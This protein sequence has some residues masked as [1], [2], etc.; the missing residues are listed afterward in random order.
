IAGVLI[1][2]NWY[3]FIY[4]VNHVN[5]KSAAFAYLVCRLLLE[6]KSYF[7]LKEELSRLKLIALGIACISILMLAQ[8]SF[9]DVLWSILI[10]ALY[11][12]YLIIQKFHDQLDK[13]NLLGIHLLISSILVLPLFIWSPESMPLDPQF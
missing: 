11:S 7:I 2:G 8:G 9:H 1:T 10:A 3:T 4:A 6:L 5:L 13:L 12:F